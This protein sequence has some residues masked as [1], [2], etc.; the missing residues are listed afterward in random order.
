ML[1]SFI[2]VLFYLLVCIVFSSATHEYFHYNVLRVLGGEGYAIFT[3]IGGAVVIEKIPPEP[4]TMTLVALAGG[5]GVGA[6]L[7][8]SAC[9]NYVSK[10]FEEM[11][12]ELA[13][14][15]AQ[16]FFGV[17]EG[18]F[19]WLPESVFTTWIQIIG[20]VGGLT[21]VALGIYLWSRGEKL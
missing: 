17:F 5:V 9:W 11:V 12:A 3:W 15:F 19:R 7:I 16:L 8:A 13:V 20:T 21:G 14:G 1:G 10:D 6:L 4:W 18:L 2:K